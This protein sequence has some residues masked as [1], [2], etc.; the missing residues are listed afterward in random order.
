MSCA[1]KEVK[2][3]ETAHSAWAGTVTVH[4]RDRPGK[5][6]KSIMLEQSISE[7]TGLSRT[8]WNYRHDLDFNASYL[9]FRNSED[10]VSFYFYHS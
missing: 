8:E 6:R 9:Y 5:R 7:L 4:W 3:S 2:L 1:I 10:A